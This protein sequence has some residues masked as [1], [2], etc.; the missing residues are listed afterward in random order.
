MAPRPHGYASRLVSADLARGGNLIV[1]ARQERINPWVFFVA[2]GVVP[3]ATLWA[4]GGATLRW[5]GAATLLLAAIGGVA[6]YVQDRRRSG[7]ASPPLTK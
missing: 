2:F 4:I 1:M 6:L 3:G 5:W 7:A